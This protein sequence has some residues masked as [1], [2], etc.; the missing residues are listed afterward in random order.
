ILD[1]GL[2]RHVPVSAATDAESDAETAAPL[3][4][5]G[6]I[7]GTVAYM[8]PEQIQG[9]PLDGRSDIFSLGCVLYE[10]IVGQPP[11]PA[12]AGGEVTAAILRDP[13]ARFLDDA[14]PIALERAVFRCLEKNREARFQSAKDLGFALRMPSAVQAPATSHRPVSAATPTVAVLP[15]R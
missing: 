2:A 15:F 6:T 7:A 14:V 3:T 12:A 1:F 9:R 11:F 5:T 10:M 13:V 8:S 4:E